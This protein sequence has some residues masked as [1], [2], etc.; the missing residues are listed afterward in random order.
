MKKFLVYTLL[1]VGL[2][3]LCLST[4]LLFKKTLGLEGDYLSAF[5][6][7]IAA[8]VA[9][10]LF[11]DW[12]DEQEYQ[13]KKEFIFKVRHIYDEL[14]DL[15]FNHIDA[16]AGLIYKL[17]NNLYDSEFH[18]ECFNSFSIFKMKIDFLITKILITLEEY[19]VVS[20]QKEFIEELDKTLVLKQKSI[21]EAYQGILNDIKDKNINSK[22][23]CQKFEEF[24]NVVNIII[25]EIY[26]EIIS[27][28]IKQLRPF[29][30]IHN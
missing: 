19:E 18:L 9:V 6:T 17:K 1:L 29:R 7:T 20:N 28:L 25:G 13:T 23:V 14:H 5:S 2:F 16:R 3:L 12:R 27:E 26:Q 22:D 4:S 24:N 8:L 11:N 15:N 30:K 21:H 10:L